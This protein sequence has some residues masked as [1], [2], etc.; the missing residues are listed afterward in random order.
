MNTITPE[1]AVQ[2]RDEARRVI[3]QVER[4]IV[5]KRETIELL[6]IALLAQGH[7]LIEDIPGVGKTTLT[8]AMAKA[9]G[10]TF[11]RI[12][13]T[14]DLLPGDVTGLT[15]YNQKTEEF[16]FNPGPIFAHLV[17]ADEINRATPK[18]Q[19]A[20][21]EAMGEGHVTA[22]GVT[23][24]LPRPFFVIATQNPVEYRGTYPLP[25]AQMDRFLLRVRLGYPERKEEEE[26]LARHS[27]VGN[28]AQGQQENSP[29]DALVTRAEAVLQAEQAHDLQRITT[30]VHLSQAAREYIVAITAGTRGLPQIALGASPRASLDLQRAAQ[31][32]AIIAGREFV[33]PDDIKRLAPHVLSHRLILQGTAET[34]MSGTTTQ[35]VLQRLLDEL[36]I[37]AV[38]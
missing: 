1:A 9:I 15:I 32:A 38:P 33:I 8:K 35:G 36:P 6:V 22:D 19:S 23:H 4:V 3:N 5:G 13:F 24:P 7:V 20:L 26:L 34:A 28:T 30:C 25:E 12:Q 17:L 27:E 31:A 2:A 29:S 37:P 11:K 10:G 14:P 18:T 21:L 16:V